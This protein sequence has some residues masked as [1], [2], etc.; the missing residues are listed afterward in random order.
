MGEGAVVGFEELSIPL[1]TSNRL[2]RPD[3]CEQVLADGCADMVSMARPL[4][5][6][7]EFV[8]QVERM[9]LDDFTRARLMTRKE[10]DDRPF[11]FRVAAR[12]AY[13]MAPVL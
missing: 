2:N 11:W 1:V 3:I 10:L 13:L 9:L 6:D 8:S 7:A 4:L 5:A 12:A